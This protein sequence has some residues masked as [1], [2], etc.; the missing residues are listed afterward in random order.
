MTVAERLR[1]VEAAAKAYS[2][3]DA[4]IFD[5]RKRDPSADL[6]LL[7]SDMAV[8]RENLFAALR[9]AGSGE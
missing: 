8:A 4:A 3:A 1:R 2:D 6:Y 9:A 5:A 7:F